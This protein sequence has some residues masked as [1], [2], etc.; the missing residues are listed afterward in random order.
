[1]V[2]NGKTLSGVPRPEKCIWSHCD[3]WLFYLKI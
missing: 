2:Y 1:M 3:L